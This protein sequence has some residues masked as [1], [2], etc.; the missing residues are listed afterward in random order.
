M[1]RL[2]ISL[3]PETTDLVKVS[4]PTV[5]FS[6]VMTELFS[7]LLVELHSRYYYDIKEKLP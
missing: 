4:D 7:I 3:I 6:V 2:I 1:M 5:E